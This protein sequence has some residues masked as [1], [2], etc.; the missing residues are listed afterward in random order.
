MGGSVVVNGAIAPGTN[1]V[2]AIVH[3]LK[4]LEASRWRRVRG[5]TYVCEINGTNATA[6]DAGGRHRSRLMCRPLPAALSPSSSPCR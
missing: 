4:H 1:G 5:G 3:R 2:E 6:R